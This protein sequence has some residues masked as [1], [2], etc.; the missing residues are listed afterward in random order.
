MP[1]PD[2]KKTEKKTRK[3]Y[4][5]LMNGSSSRKV[6]VNFSDEDA[7][8]TL[9]FHLIN[10]YFLR[11][12]IYRD[13]QGTANKE[14]TENIGTSRAN[15]SGTSRADAKKN[16][17]IGRADKLENSSIGGIDKLSTG[18]A[19][20]KENTDGANREKDTSRADIKEEPGTSTANKPGISGVDKPGS[21]GAAKSNIDGTDKQKTS[22]ADKLGIGKINKAEKE[23]ARKQAIA[24]AS[25]FSFYN[26]FFFFFSFLE[27]E[28]S[29]SLFCSF[30]F[31][32]SSLIISV[33]QHGLSSK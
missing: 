9:L 22:E 13:N 6:E 26:V 31:S 2:G 33:K 23:L 30:L 10:Y 21:G 19:D 17:G 28:T 7:L 16:S 14:E 4:S 29:S 1:R 32:S 18:K 25:F 3:K 5:I 15:K 8:F 27:L 11:A 12:S 24:Q 20:K